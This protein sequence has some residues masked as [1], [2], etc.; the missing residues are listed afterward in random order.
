M[1]LIPELQVP[2]R[3]HPCPSVV[4]PDPEESIQERGDWFTDLVLRFFTWLSR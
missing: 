1:K 2:I 4:K 3:V